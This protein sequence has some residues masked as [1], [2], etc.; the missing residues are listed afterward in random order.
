MSIATVGQKKVVTPYGHTDTGKKQQV[1][2]MFNNIAHRYDFLNRSLS[3]GIDVLWR[4][5]MIAQ[6][7]AK[8]PKVILD[9][10]TGTGDV[11][12]EAMS[13]RPE[14]I[15]GLDISTGMLELGRQKVAKRG[16]SET[17]EMVEGDSENMPFA[18]NTFDAVTVAFGVRNFENLNKGLKEINRVLQKDGKLVVLEFS[19]PRSFPVKQLYWFYFNNILPVFGKM[20]SKDDA[21]YTYL[22]ESVKAFADGDDFL[23]ELKKAGFTATHRRPLTF[24]IATIYTGV[25]A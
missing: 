15:V 9:V 13:L 10:A 12:L 1:A 24:G 4:K 2:E 11:A 22:P 3:M 17:I 18:D 21:A 8:Q 19:Q 6:L 23:A 7:K 14:R 5:K 25:K 20:L 16:L